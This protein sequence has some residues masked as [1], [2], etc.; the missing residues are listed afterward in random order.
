MIPVKSSSLKNFMK[1]ILQFILKILSK[2]TLWRYKPDVISITGSVGKTSAKEAIYAVLGSYYSVRRSTKNYN[3]EIGVPITVIGVESAGSSFFG[4][5]AVFLKAFKN[6]IIKEKNYPEI[7]IIEMGADRPGDIEYLVK[8]IKSKTAVITA[9]GEIPVHVE[10]FSGPLS[11]AREKSK[12]VEGLSAG[13]YAV[14]NYDDEVVREMGDK[15]KAHVISY[16]FGEGADVR[17][18]G[19]SISLG[20][21]NFKVD[22]RGS[23]IP[24]KIPSAFGKGQVYS[25]LAAISVGLVYK[26]NLV[27]ISEALMKYKSPQ[28]R[29]NLIRGVKNTIIINDTYNASPASMKEAIETLDALPAKRKV[30]VLGDM[31]EI[32]R[33]TEAAHRA[34]GELVIKTA[35]LLF[36]VGERAKFISDEAKSMGFSEERIFEFCESAEAGVIL[37]EKIKEGDLILIKGSRAM[38]MEKIVEEISALGTIKTE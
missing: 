32:G 15:I 10:F 18:E 26:L 38:K 27:E 11:V 14:L 5:L 36:A 37:Q 12:L 25:A 6:F 33:F 2:L 19:I 34:V 1:S 30:A 7:L 29:L 21:T 16:G 24:V 4:W 22:C 13:E 31:L 35:D 3:N 8:F 17:G 23:F 20:G 28:G 9:I